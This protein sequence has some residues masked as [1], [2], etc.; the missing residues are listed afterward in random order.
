MTRR[1]RRTIRRVQGA[2][3]DIGMLAVACA[4]LLMVVI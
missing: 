3:F 2:A 1:Y 4:L